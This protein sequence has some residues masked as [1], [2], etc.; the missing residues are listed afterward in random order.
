[1]PPPYIFKGPFTKPPKGPQPTQPMTDLAAYPILTEEV[2]FPPSPL[3]KS[4]SMATGQAPGGG[5]GQLAQTA[6]NA[7]ANVLG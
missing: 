4:G 1:M 6:M 2:G 7:V 3:A 5:T